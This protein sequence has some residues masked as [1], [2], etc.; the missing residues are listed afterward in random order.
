M[1]YAMGATILQFVFFI[2]MLVSV[3]NRTFPEAIIWGIL[4]IA[5]YLDEVIST[6][7]HS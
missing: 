6:I 5:A 7:R 4:L 1:V 2:G 3:S